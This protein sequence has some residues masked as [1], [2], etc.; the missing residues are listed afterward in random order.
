VSD[1]YC[2]SAKHD[3]WLEK[4]FPIVVDHPAQETRYIHNVHYCIGLQNNTVYERL[5]PYCEKQ[6]WLQ[7]KECMI[8]NKIS[9]GQVA[10]TYKTFTY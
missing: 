8:A 6:E 2:S 3:S 1:V 5:Y 7:V 10:N 9:T 4:L